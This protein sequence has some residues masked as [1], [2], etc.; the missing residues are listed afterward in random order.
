METRKAMPRRQR[1]GFFEK[2]IQGRGIDIGCGNDPLT[3][4]CDKWDLEQGDATHMDGI[5]RG[6]YDWVYSSHCLEDIKYAN[7]ALLTWWSLLKQDGYLIIYVPHR[8]LFERRMTLPSAGNARHQWYFLIDRSEKPVTIGLVP[9]VTTVLQSNY[10]IEYVKKCDEG[11]SCQFLP[12]EG[13]PDGYQVIAHG[14]FSIEI[15][16]RKIGRP[17]YVE[18]IVRG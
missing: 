15:V 3:A 17:Q 12:K 5:E 8:D 16:I 4:D 13:F 14:E 18:D 2:Y 1:E 10:D 9:F 7:K 11:Y 6:S